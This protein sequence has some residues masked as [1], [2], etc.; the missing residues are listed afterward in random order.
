VK[1]ASDGESARRPRLAVTIRT[2]R[3]RIGKSQRWL[4][5]RVGVVHG[6]L[7]NWETGRSRPAKR[8]LPALASALGIELAALEWQRELWAKNGGGPQ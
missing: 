8:H 1:R 4:A 6:T 7:E 3:E 2:R 5:A